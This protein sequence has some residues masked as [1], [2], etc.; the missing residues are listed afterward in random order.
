MAGRKSE[1]HRAPELRGVGFIRVGIG[2]AERLHAVAAAAYDHDHSSEVRNFRGMID[3][4]PQVLARMHQ[5]CTH[6]GRQIGAPQLALQP[7]G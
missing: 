1:E 5:Q 7:G 2:A 4:R 6:H 3:H